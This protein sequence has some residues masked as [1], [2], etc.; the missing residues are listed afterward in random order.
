VCVATLIVILGT[1]AVFVV[2]RLGYTV[3]GVIV[4]VFYVVMYFTVL[5]FARRKGTVSA[6]GITRRHS[7][8][9][10]VAGVLLR[11]AIFIEQF[12]NAA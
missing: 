3:A 4:S 7:L 9:A 11:G 12:H 2:P 1:M 5:S 8:V 10:V 6:I